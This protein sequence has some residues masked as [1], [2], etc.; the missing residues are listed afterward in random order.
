MHLINK[1]S[2]IWKKKLESQWVYNINKSK[3]N[4]H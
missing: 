3:G 1:Y 4:K 2:E